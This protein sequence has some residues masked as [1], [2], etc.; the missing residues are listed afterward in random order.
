MLTSE[1]VALKEVSTKL[2]S[3]F[4]TSDEQASANSASSPTEI[5]TFSDADAFLKLF[6]S[7]CTV[8]LL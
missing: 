1:P 6:V 8:K 5:T 7:S 4:S 3:T 2:K